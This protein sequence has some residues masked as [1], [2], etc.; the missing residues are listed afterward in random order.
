MRIKQEST[1]EEY[2]NLFDKLVAPL[3]DL[4]EKVVEIVMN[5][6]LPWIKAEVDFCEPKGLAQIM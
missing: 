4:Q 5:G 3:P 6:L 1:V 2:Q